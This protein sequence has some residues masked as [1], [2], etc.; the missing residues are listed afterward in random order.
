MTF[1]EWRRDLLSRCPPPGWKRGPVERLSC[2]RVANY[3]D[4][5]TVY[6]FLVSVPVER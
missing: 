1:D 3:G 2:P 5:W 6:G 4:S